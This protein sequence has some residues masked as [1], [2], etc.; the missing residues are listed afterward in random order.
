MA[1]FV[2]PHCLLLLALITSMCLLSSMLVYD[3]SFE[4]YNTKTDYHVNV[5]RIKIHPHPIEADNKLSLNILA[6]AG[7]GISKGKV[8]IDGKHFFFY[9]HLKMKVKTKQPTVHSSTDCSKRQLN[10]APTSSIATR[11]LWTTIAW[12]LIEDP[13]SPAE[14]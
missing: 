14:S 11:H 5:T 6:S 12:P 1:I 8:A 13:T 4:Y 3:T 10:I 7:P 9:V 2:G